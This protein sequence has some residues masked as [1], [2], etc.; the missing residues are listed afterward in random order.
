MILYISQ[1]ACLLHLW[2]HKGITAHS[3]L[4]IQCRVC[5]STVSLWRLVVL[6]MA[7]FVYTVCINEGTLHNWLQPY[8]NSTER[9]WVFIMQ[10]TSIILQKFGTYSKHITNVRSKFLH[11]PGYQFQQN[12]QLLFNCL[13]NQMLKELCHYIL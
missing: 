3:I 4:L 11:Q 2:T 6:T 8:F 7:V 1:N 12:N 10:D 5:A 9:Y 13:K